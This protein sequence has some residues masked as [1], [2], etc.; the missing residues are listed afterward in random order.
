MCYSY[1]GKS[2]TLSCYFSATTALENKLPAYERVALRKRKLNFVK[3]QVHSLLQNAAIFTQLILLVLLVL[4]MCLP[5]A[6]A[7]FLT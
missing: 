4:K 3:Y 7:S 1:E 2:V 5:F 6:L